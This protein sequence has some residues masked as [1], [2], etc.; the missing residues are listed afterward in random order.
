MRE[1]YFHKRKL[2]ADLEYLNQE[3]KSEYE[4]KITSKFSLLLPRL[5]Q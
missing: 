1:K 5:I 3:Y 2:N 4:T